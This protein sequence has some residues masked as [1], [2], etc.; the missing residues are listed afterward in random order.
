MQKRV[1]LR[2][3]LTCHLVYTPG[4]GLALVE[5]KLTLFPA[6]PCIDRFADT[7]LL[8]KMNSETF[9]SFI[10]P[11]SVSLTWADAQTKS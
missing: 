5:T 2:H 10:P 11:W 7:V 9:R 1:P 4:E 8:M 6:R 3:S